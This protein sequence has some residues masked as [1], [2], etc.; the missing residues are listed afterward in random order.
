MANTQ[1][2]QTRPKQ[3]VMRLDESTLRVFTESRHCAREL[4]VFVAYTSR[5][6]TQA[7]LDS[8]LALTRCLDARVKLFAVR[9]V[10]FPV[11]LEQPDSASQFVER[12]LTGMARKLEKPVDV[13]VVIARDL[14]TGL[15]RVLTANSL[16]VVPAKKRWWPTAEARLAQ[17]LA[18]AGHSVA[19]VTV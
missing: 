18:R 4:R 16:V 2:T 1:D 8:V 10:P 13:Q 3:P 7:A 17:V 12:E 11:P 9:I 19:L 14:D 5:E 6:R 15:Q